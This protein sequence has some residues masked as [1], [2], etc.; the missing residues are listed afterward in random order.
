MRV[1]ETGATCYTFYFHSSFK[2][3]KIHRP[4]CDTM[5]QLP[6][7]CHDTLLHQKQ[8]NKPVTKFP[9]IFSPFLTISLSRAGQYLSHPVFSILCHVF[10]QLLFR[11][12]VVP[13]SLFR[14]ASGQ[15]WLR[16]R[17]KQWPN[18]YSLLFS[19]K[20]SICFMSA[21]FLMSSFL[22]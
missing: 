16:S 14:S 2:I 18:H 17:L 13:P 1:G 3:S 6:N 10:S 19:R 7:Y 9:T 22:M 20:V 8:A 4:F 11:L 5:P 12:Y 21:S 15:M